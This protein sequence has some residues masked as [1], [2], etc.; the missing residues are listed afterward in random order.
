LAGNVNFSSCEG[1]ISVWF[2]FSPAAAAAAATSPSNVTLS[3]EASYI[4]FSGELSISVSIFGG[5]AYDVENLSI[6]VV[7]IEF[8]HQTTTVIARDSRIVA[9]ITLMEIGKRTGRVSGASPAERTWKA[10][11]PC[12][13][14]SS[15]GRYL[16][17]LSERQPNNGSIG[18]FDF[19]SS[20]YY[21]Q[22]YY[23]HRMSVCD[24]RDDE[25]HV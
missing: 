22:V 20:Q 12:G 10:A 18:E 2:I 5:E 21:T 6:E 24:E 7:C 9:S 3:V 4:V 11:I 8:C 15:P 19:L 23:C 13:V 17:Q 1:L 25:L 14:I 16:V